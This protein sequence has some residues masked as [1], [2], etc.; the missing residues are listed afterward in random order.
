MLA[1]PYFRPFFNVRVLLLLQTLAH[2]F[3]MAERMKNNMSRK[4]TM[5]NGN[6]PVSQVAGFNLFQLP[7]DCD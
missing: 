2:H 3:T 6:D 1:S 5:E 4:T 7:D